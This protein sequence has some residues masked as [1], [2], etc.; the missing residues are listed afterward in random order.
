MNRAFVI[1]LLVILPLFG[2]GCSWVT[3]TPSG[4]KA[5]VLSLAEVGNCTKTGSTT[6]YT[7]AAIGPVGRAESVVSGELALLA[8]NAAEGLG[9][10]TV[11]PVTGIQDG[12]QTFDVYN[13]V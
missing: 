2:A 9:G 4:E 8:R 10:D 11:V 3:L 1:S 5:R 12:T 7:K 6:V 13:C